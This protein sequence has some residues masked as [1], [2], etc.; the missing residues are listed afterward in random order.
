MVKHETEYDVSDATRF[1]P[2]KRGSLETQLANPADEIAYTAHDLDD[3]L[4]SGLVKPSQ[5]NHLDWWQ[6]L[7]ESINWNGTDFNDMIRYRMVR[8][9]IG[10]LVRDQVEATVRRL[11][12]AE[13][14]SPDDVRKLAENVVG[15]ST[16]IAKRTRELKAFLYENLYRHPHVMRMQAKAERVLQ[17]LFEAYMQEPMQMPLAEQQKFEER[18]KERVICDYIAGMTDRFA[19]EEYAKLFDPTVPV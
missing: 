10:L 5:L 9:L 1:D 13:A 16:E 2:E 19:L 14:Q 17:A 6:A 3:G 15:H 4:R 11:D 12:K 8:R 7:K 18:S